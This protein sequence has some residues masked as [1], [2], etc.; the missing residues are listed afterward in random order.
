MPNLLNKLLFIIVV[1][2]FI[3]NFEA[4]AQQI[5]VV[6]DLKF[7]SKKL[8]GVEKKAKPYIYKNE[9]KIWK[10]YNPVNMTFGGLLYIYQNAITY[11]FSAGC[12]YNPTCSEFSKQCINK[13][14]LF[15][16]FILSADRLSRCSRIVVSDIHPLKIDPHN[17]KAN[18]LIDYYK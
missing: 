14:G 5:N 16:G 9:K 2:Q 18:D 15:K 7:V 6:E 12:I 13:Y 3:V 4:S 10:K 17:H 1:F 11:Q 8:K